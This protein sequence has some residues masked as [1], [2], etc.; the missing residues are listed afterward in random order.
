FICK[1]FIGDITDPLKEIKQNKEKYPE[2]SD[3]VQKNFTIQRKG[4]RSN[5]S[6]TSGIWLPSNNLSIVGN[7]PSFGLQLGGRGTHHGVDITMQFRFLKSANLYTVKRNNT[8]YKRDHF[9][10]GYIG[11]DYTF[12]FISKT[13]FDLGWMAGAGYDGFD[14]ANSSDENH[15][16]NYLKPLSISSFNANT[17]VRFNYYFNP[18]FYLGLQSRYNWINYANSGGTNLNGDAISIDL[19][20]GVNHKRLY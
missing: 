16:N 6:F 17:G 15:N 11:L 12:Y 9:F 4:F 8:L 3:L 20:I 7:H 2:L 5:Y 13:K 19:I 14:I 10:G 1:V 18:S